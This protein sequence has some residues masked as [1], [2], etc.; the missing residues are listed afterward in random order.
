MVYCKKAV[1]SESKFFILMLFIIGLLIGAAVVLFILQNVVPVTVT[2]LVWQ[3]SGTIAVLVLVAVIAGVLIGLLLALPAIL[4]KEFKNA[5]LKKHNKKLADDLEEHKQRLIETPTS[6]TVVQTTEPV[7][8]EN[9]TT[10][11]TTQ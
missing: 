9:A 6:P 8:V 7:L 4:S 2:F 11:E 3:F 10:V 1:L 5:S